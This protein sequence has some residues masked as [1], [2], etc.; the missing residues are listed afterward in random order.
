MPI[1]QTFLK[2]QINNHVEEN[3]RL[4]IITIE[5]VKIITNEE[6]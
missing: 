3:K 4:E 1:I 6:I 5:I 2:E